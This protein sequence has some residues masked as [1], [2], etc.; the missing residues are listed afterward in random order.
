MSL[1]ELE[2][3]VKSL[4]DSFRTLQDVQE[5]KKLHS[6]Y[7]FYLEHW[8][9]EEVIALFSDG[10]D[11]SVELSDSGVFLGKEGVKRYFGATKP[12]AEYMHLVMQIDGVIDVAPDGKTAKGRWYGLGFMA[13]PRDEGVH[14]GW[15]VGIYTCEYVKDDGKWK[16]KKLH[17]YRIFSA[18]YHEG[19]VK[20]ER[21]VKTA[22]SSINR[23]TAYNTRKPDLPTS[24]HKPYP[25][26]YVVPFHYKHPITGK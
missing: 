9:A 10:P 18:P 26:G 19:W 25:S 22:M 16:F 7:A 14:A 15:N 11:V 3:K 12:T 24:V 8:M 20:P 2:A 13:I 1:K 5:I 17:W 23:E 4:E 21:L 6:I